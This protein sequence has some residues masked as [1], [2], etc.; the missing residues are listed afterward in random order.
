MGVYEFGVTGLDALLPEALVPGTLVVVAGSPGSG[1]TTL[2]TTLCLKNAVKGFKCLY[3]SFQEDK[4]KLFRNMLRLGLNL[5]EV[6]SKGLMDFIKLPLSSSA[7]DIVSELGALVSKGRYNVIVVDSINPLLK[8]VEG[9]LNRRAYLQNFFA[10]LPKITEGVVTLLYEAPED[11]DTLS[12][13]DIEFVADIIIYLRQKVERRLVSRELEIRKARN[14]S[15]NVVQAPLTITEG[16]GLEV[17][18]P[19]TFEEIQPPGESLIKP[20]L[21]NILKTENCVELSDHI[22]NSL[23]KGRVIY[24]TYP[25]DI[26][27]IEPLT[28]TLFLA[29]IVNAKVLL[30]SYRY[31]SADIRHLLEKTLKQHGIRDTELIDKYIIIKSLNPLGVN[32]AQINAY[33]N[34]WIKTLKPD[35]VYFHGVETAQTV[36]EF[37][38]YAYLLVNQLNFL[39][40]E[41]ILTIREGSYINKKLHRFN[42]ILSDTIVKFKPIKEKPGYEIRIW[43]RGV[44]P[45][46]TT[47]EKLSACGRE[48]FKFLLKKLQL[49]DVTSTQ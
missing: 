41:Q 11:I 31:S 23:V 42:S 26:Q 5:T 43:S 39:R 45:V 32:V 4:E 19:Y 22:L 10:E 36:S 6:A 3:V 44:K 34:E 13:G 2:A 8:A 21:M 48:M 29:T 38:T 25:S 28:H 16:K 14:V 27:L 7:D 46:T 9:D 37:N 17:W 20:E 47:G 49:K 30:I 33:E 15:L 12:L 35:I 1:K 18:I 40:K 24:V